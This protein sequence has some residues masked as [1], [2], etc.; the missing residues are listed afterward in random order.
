VR[1]LVVWLHLLA[2]VVWIGGVLHQS[3]VL[4]PAARAGR[5]DAFVAAARRARPLAWTAVSLVVLTGFYNVTQL[6]TLARVMESG[7]ALIL[8][9]KFIVVIAAIA[10]AGQRDFAQ[11]PRAHALLAAGQDPARVLT[12][13][14]WLDRVVLILAAAIIY[15]GLSLA[16]LAR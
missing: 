10:L 7:A 8:A 11:L 13:I 4:L 16:R 12:A 14:A 3:Q 5:A 9:G 6:G 2:V 15:L 1:L